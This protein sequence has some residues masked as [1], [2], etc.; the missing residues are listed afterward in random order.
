LFIIYIF[1]NTTVARQ[2]PVR[3]LDG[4]LQETG[5][6]RIDLLSMDIEL[7][8]PLALH[9]FSIGNYRP[10]LAVVEA[11]GQTRQAILDY[12]AEAGYVVVGRYLR[13]DP[14]N[15]YFAPHDAGRSPV[16]PAVQ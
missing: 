7:G 3:T 15:L 10:R 6:A 16:Q 4:I 9:H 1:T 11:H 8:E 12:F 2:V 13:A 14:Q 5:T